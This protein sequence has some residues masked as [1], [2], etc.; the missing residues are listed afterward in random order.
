MKYALLAALLFASFSAHAQ[1]YGSSYGS[2]DPYGSI[3]E[4]SRYTEQLNQQNQM[5][6]DEE[7]MQDQIN[8]QHEEIERQLEMQ[9]Q[10]NSLSPAEQMGYGH[11]Q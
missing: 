10:F 3:A 7:R 6:A 4:S 2:N 9:N 8:Q 1:D 11:I 5:R